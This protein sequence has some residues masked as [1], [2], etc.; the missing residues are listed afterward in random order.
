[1]ITG[2]NGKGVTVLSN[3]TRILGTRERGHLLTVKTAKR[4]NPEAL[5]AALVSAD[6]AVY[7]GEGRRYAVTDAQH[8]C[9]D[10][11]LVLIMSTKE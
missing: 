1:M 8:L 7:V 3:S 5:K 4:T 10:T 9:D 2:R 6:L 11:Y